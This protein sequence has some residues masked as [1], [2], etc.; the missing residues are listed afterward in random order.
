MGAW[1]QFT[2]KDVTITPFTADKGFTFTGYAITGSDVGINIYLGKNVH[3]TSSSNVQT[4]FE[5]SSSLNS[6]YNS[7]KQLYY[8]NYITSSRGDFVNT[9]SILPGVTR[10]DDRSIGSIESPLYD[11]YLQSSLLQERNFPTAPESKISMFSIPTKLYGEKIIPGTFEFTSTT[12]AGAGYL[13]QLKDDGEGNIIS[14]STDAIVGQIF[15]SHGTVVLTQDNPNDLGKQFTQ[16]PS[17]LENTTFS[18]SSSLTIYEQQYKCTVL[19]N[20]FGFSLN[21]SLLTSSIAGADNQGYYAFTS[22]SFFEPYVTCVGLYN[23]RQELVAVGKLSF[24]LPV[25]RFT[26]TTVIVNFDI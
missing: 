22:G 20:E 16:D 15:Y 26:D 21:P 5:Y 10:E 18:F 4:G 2:T 24:P 17:F 7:A 19:E 13:N 3:Y 25:S 8:T 9:G 14:G 11:N 23:E 12:G 6:I 1:K